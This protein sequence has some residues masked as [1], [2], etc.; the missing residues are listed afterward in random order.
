MSLKPNLDLH[1]QKPK[2]G[3]INLSKMLKFLFFALFII[4]SL[5]VFIDKLNLK[6][7]CDFTFLPMLSHAHCQGIFP[8][9]NIFVD[10]ND[11]GES[12]SGTELFW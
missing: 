4:S 5:C 11:T 10:L 8:S 3:F 9:D 1:A 7:A 2:H 6:K 12:D